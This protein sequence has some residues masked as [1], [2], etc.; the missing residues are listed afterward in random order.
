MKPKRSYTIMIVPHARAEFRRVKISHR[1]VL[2]A[3][4]LAVLL[5]LGGL[6]L[7]F[8]FVRTLRQSN[9]VERLRQENTGLKTANARFDAALAE[10][11]DQIT[12][13]ENKSY[14]FAL[15][16]GVEDFQASRQGAGGSNLSGMPS[17]AP[18]VSYLRGQLKGLRERT[19]ALEGAY[20]ALE[21]VYQDQSLLL[22]ST[23]SI[24]PVKGILGHGFGWRRDPFT[25]QREL[26]KGI[27]IS[28]PTGRKVVAPADGIVIRTTRIQG[29]GRVVYLSHGNGITTRYGHLSE[30]NVKLGQ[31][32][33]RGEVIA[34]VGSTGRSTGPHLHYEVL[35]H[36]KKVD[37]M[38]YIL[39]DLPSL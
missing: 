36:K 6:L 13:F 7:P 8:Y 34:F 21:K 25:G 19:Q 29:Y 11:K 23:P 17:G 35:V 26:H 33:K 16:A 10:L 3:G 15:M 12:D 18:S 22:A 4:G 14:K 5:G 9:Q 38:K 2:T 30:L 32:I 31:K 24:L 27:D 1:A 37:P 28:A 39:E 20:S